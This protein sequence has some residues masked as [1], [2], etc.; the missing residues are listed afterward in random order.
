VEDSAKSSTGERLKQTAL[1]LGEHGA[2]MLSAVLKSPAAI[3]ASLRIARAFVRLRRLVS[4]NKGLARR[5]DA[6]ERK[7][8]GQGRGITDLFEAIDKPIDG[9]PE[10][11]RETGSPS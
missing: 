9:P 1:L 11:P 8:A 4:A 5:I 3:A 10:E 6:L 2:V 7:V